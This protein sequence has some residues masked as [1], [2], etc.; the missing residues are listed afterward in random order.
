MDELLRSAGD[1]QNSGPPPLLE[2]HEDQ[3]RSDET[4]AQAQ[5]A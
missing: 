3:N 1:H 4:R 2:D 5:D